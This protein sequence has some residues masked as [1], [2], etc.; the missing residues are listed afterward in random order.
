MSELQWLYVIEK[1]KELADKKNN[2]YYERTLFIM[3]ALYLMYLRVSELVVS[4]RWA[5]KMNN[6]AKDSNNYCLYLLRS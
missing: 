3:S 4:T 2:D 1:V 6:F 5:P